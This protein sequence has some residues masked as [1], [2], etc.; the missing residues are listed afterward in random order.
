MG[1]TLVCEDDE[2]IRLL[3][4]GLLASAGHC[5]V[6]AGT[7]ADALGSMADEGFD[8]VVT[9]LGLPDGSGLDVCEAAS[10]AGSRVVV[11]TA[12]PRL[13]DVPAVRGCADVIVTKPFATSTFLD[14]V[15]LPGDGTNGVAGS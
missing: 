7:V 13:A 3:L 11:V 2:D 12:N 14:A 9:D 6:E 5:V 15:V 1:R 4:A 8:L 10:R